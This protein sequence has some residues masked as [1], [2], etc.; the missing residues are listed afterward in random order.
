MSEEIIKILDNLG[1][2]IGIT[3]DWTSENILPYLQDLMSRFIG[4]KNVQ[5]IMWVVISAI[6]I[7]VTILIIAGTIKYIKKQDKASHEYEDKVFVCGLID[8]AIGML[9]IIFLTILLCNTFGLIQNIY[10]PELTLLEYITNYGG[11][12]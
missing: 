10:T 6:I 11:T 9:T 5:A 1:E 12:R 3:I 4:L 7:L 8:F 2:K